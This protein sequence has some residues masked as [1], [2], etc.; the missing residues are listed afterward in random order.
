MYLCICIFIYKFITLLFDKSKLKKEYLKNFRYFKIGT[1]LKSHVRNQL[2]M[3][4]HNS[5]KYQ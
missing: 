4:F 3:K 2:E 1:V 5:R